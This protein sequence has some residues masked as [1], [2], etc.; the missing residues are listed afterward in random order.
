MNKLSRALAVTLMAATIPA[1]IVLA[2]QA[3]ADDQTTGEKSG[4][5]RGPSP[6]TIARLED[7]RIAFAKAALKLTPEQEKLWAPVEQ[8]IRANFADRQKRREEWQAK[9]EERRAER[10]DGEKLALPERIE[11]RSERLTEAASR[12]NE[13]AAK[14]KEFAEVL[15][16]L[17]AT[18][19]DEQKTVASRVLGQF[20]HGPRGPH[21]AM[22]HRGFGHGSHGHDDDR[23]HDAE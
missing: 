23:G 18:F 21:W 10:K 5:R 7:G 9:R 1:T 12:L 8:K 11:K 17:Y 19:N 4:S 6:E 16:P 20:G 3:P 14:A 13:R 2:Q 22:M 15:K